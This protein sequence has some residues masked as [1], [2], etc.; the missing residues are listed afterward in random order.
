VSLAALDL[1]RISEVDLEG[2][3]LDPGIS[4]I[5][6]FRLNSCV[7]HFLLKCT[8]L[9]KLRRIRVLECAVEFMMIT[10]PVIGVT[11]SNLVTLAILDEPVDSRCHG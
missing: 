11:S 6:C 7:S 10:I 3:G 9:C 5:P 4:G 8:F 1:V 2:S